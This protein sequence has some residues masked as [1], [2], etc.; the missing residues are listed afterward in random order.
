VARAAVP[1][2]VGH[3]EDDATRRIE[4]AGLVASPQ[5]VDPDPAPRTIEVRGPRRGGLR[6]ARRRGPDGRQQRE[7]S[8]SDGPSAAGVVT[9][10]IVDP[11]VGELVSAGGDALVA[12]FER[13]F[14]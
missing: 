13:R 2:V 5:V 14:R 7:P 12:R 3:H 1:D 10:V 4:E 11:V 6:I 8:T 9:S